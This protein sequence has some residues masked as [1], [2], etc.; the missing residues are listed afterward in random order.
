MRRARTAA[1][2]VTL[3]LAA[4]VP[5]GAASPARD[6]V[7]ARSDGGLV[8]LDGA[9]GRAV[10]TLP[11]GAGSAGWR[12]LYTAQPASSGTQLEAIDPATGA[13]LRRRVIAGSWQ[14]PLAAADGTRAG[15][16]PGG[17]FLALA[18]TAND[19]SRSRFAVLS[20]S[21]TGAVQHLGEPGQLD[22]DALAPA[23]DLLYVIEHLGGAATHYD[24]RMLHVAS[25]RMD[26]RV[27]VDKRE[28]GERMTGYPLARAVGDGGWVYTAYRRDGRLPFIH[29][30][31]TSAGFAWCI[32]LPAGAWALAFSHGTL[33]GASPATGLMARIDT[34][35]QPPQPQV[36][37][38][39]PPAR[40]QAA[41]VG[42]VAVW[43]GGRRVFVDGAGPLVSLSA[44]TLGDAHRLATGAGAT[45]A[46]SADGA[47][48]YT[49]SGGRL[50]RIDRAQRR[51]TPLS[52]TVDAP[53]DA[54]LAVLPA[55][56]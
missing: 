36:V 50:L 21:L 34:S 28:I 55:R 44:D 16:A 53:L 15:L 20:T 13:V 42:G 54:V 22:L 46:V 17:R 45:L 33:Y 43:P 27:I 11:D 30:L 51:A 39:S 40:S 6:L 12:V 26:P 38:F 3:G 24:V 25:G 49:V 23:G 29:A 7:L 9:T 4:A 1:L 41:A 10:R 31:D 19:A 56:G 32:D 47:R 37:R 2:T 48:L 8:V 35:L 18:A 52:G 14:L 5:G